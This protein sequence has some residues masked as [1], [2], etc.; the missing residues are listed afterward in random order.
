MA[1]ES[2]VDHVRKL[3]FKKY[4]KNHKIIFIK[5]V[6]EKKITEDEL[7][8]LLGFK[9]KKKI[10]VCTTFI[11]FM[12]NFTNLEINYLRLSLSLSWTCVFKV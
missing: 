1:K 5:K 7:I 3:L 6:E 9:K 10:R 12:I 8:S 2:L 11:V 4:M